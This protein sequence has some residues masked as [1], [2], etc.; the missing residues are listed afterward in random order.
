[1][2]I[3]FTIGQVFPA[4]QEKE[5][6]RTSFL[7]EPLPETVTCDKR[8]ARQYGYVVSLRRYVVNLSQ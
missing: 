7:R 1:M 5:Q 6:T 8:R 2:R 4:G 3:S